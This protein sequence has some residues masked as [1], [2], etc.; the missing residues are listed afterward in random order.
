MRYELFE[1]IVIGGIIGFGV[2]LV[3][4]LSVDAPQSQTL[5]LAVVATVLCLVQIGLTVR[6][7]RR[8][9][10]NEHSRDEQHTLPPRR[11]RPRQDS[12]AQEEDHRWTGLAVDDELTQTI[13]E[14][15]PP[16]AH[17]G[18]SPA[19]SES[20]TET[21]VNGAT[22]TPSNNKTPN[23][24]SFNTNSAP[25]RDHTSPPANGTP[26]HLSPTEHSAA[27]RKPSP[28]PAVNDE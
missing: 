12:F 18:H 26:A 16:V 19:T 24:A 3:R 11:A 2:M 21:P 25:E 6:R 15:F 1:G 23:T 5:M 10:S 9:P 7:I 27:N 4:A 13:Q 28:A 22:Q 14:Q 17:T 20:A 8:T